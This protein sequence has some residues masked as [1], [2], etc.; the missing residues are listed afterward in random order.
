MKNKIINRSNH[1]VKIATLINLIDEINGN[2]ILKSIFKIKGIF[3]YVSTSHKLRQ[4]ISD[5]EDLDNTPAGSI[6]LKSNLIQ[7]ALRD[8][9]SFHYEIERILK[10]VIDNIFKNSFYTDLLKS[11]S[12]KEY[13][14][15][16]EN[17]EAPLWSEQFQSLPENSIAMKNAI[18]EIHKKSKLA[19]ELL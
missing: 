18:Q 7:E 3:W 8:G 10:F 14:K 4:V 19:L 9:F 13:Y 2:P 6:G 16:I 15:N 17:L 11:D 12:K 1:A 5:C